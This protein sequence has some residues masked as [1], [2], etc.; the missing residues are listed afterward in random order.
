MGEV[1]VGLG[2]GNLG[3]S[4]ASRTVGGGEIKERVGIQERF[5][6]VFCRLLPSVRCDSVRANYSAVPIQVSF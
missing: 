2:G 6:P 5:P 4:A 1:F 3:Q